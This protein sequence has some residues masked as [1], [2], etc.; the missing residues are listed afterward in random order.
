M[1]YRI[2]RKNNQTNE[3]IYLVNFFE[4]KENAETYVSLM[5]NIFNKEDKPFYTYSIVEVND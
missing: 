4:K 2:L 5:N 3:E 1:K